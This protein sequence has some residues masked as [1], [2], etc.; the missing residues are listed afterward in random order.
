MKIPLYKNYWDKEDVQAVIKVIRRGMYWAGGQENTMLEEKVAHYAGVKHGVSVNS[1]T[2]AL[3]AI[4]LA[5]R[6]GAGDE[7]IVPSFT[8]PPTV[9][10]VKYVGATPVFADIEEERFGLDPDDVKKRIT[11]KTR[12]IIAVHVYGLPCRIS[13]LSEIAEENNILLVED[14]AEAIG[15]KEYGKKVGGFGDAS[16]FSFAGNKII[17]TGEGGMVVTNDETMQRRLKAIR[18]KH[19]WRMSTILASLGLSQFNKIEQVISSRILCAMYLTNGFNFIDGVSPPV[20]PEGV[21]HTYQFYT[22]KAEQRD[23]LKNYLEEHGITTKIYFPPVMS[24]LPVTDA[25]ADQVLTLPIYPD[26][27]TREMNYIL[28]TINLFTKKMETPK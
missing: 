14:A 1:G 7:I 4:M 13:E 21:S 11:D 3:N 5:Y 22:I 6:L 19:S 26:L 2:S 20:E 23:K 12:A 18:N 25:V 28:K 9:N 16:I 17:S 10:A 8:Y 27:S 15:A 24:G